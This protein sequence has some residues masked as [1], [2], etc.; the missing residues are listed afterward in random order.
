M[1]T[2]LVFFICCLVATAVGTFYFD[3]SLDFQHGDVNV[4]LSAETSQSTVFGDAQN[5]S[6]LAVDGDA[7]HQDSCIRTEEESGAWWE[8]DLG[9]DVQ[10]KYLKIYNFV[11][12]DRWWR[13]NL[14]SGSGGFTILSATSSAPE[15]F[16]PTEGYNHKGEISQVRE[17]YGA[18][19]L[20]RVDV[21]AR[22]IRIQRNSWGSL[23]LCEV[24]VYT[25]EPTLSYIVPDHVSATAPGEPS[26]PPAGHPLHA[27]CLQYLNAEDGTLF[28]PAMALVKA[29]M[30]G[31]LDCGGKGFFCRMKTDSYFSGTPRDALHNNYNYGYCKDAKEENPDNN[32]P[33]NYQRPERD[34]GHCHGSHL[35]TVYEELLEDHYYRRYRGN[36]VCC[37]G[38]FATPTK[39]SGEPENNDAWVPAT[40]LM[41][42][43]DFRGVDGNNNQY[44]FDGGC[45]GDVNR[46]E[47]VDPSNFHTPEQYKA[48]HTCWELKHF[49][50][51]PEF[52]YGENPLRVTTSNPDITPAY[53]VPTL[54]IIHC[55][56]NAGDWNG[57]LLYIEGRHDSNVVVLVS[58]S[59]TVQPRTL[60]H[61][62]FMDDKPWSCSHVE[63]VQ[64]GSASLRYFHFNELDAEG[65]QA[66]YVRIAPDFELGSPVHIQIVDTETCMMSPLKSS[67]LGSSDNG[68]RKLLL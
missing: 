7:H 62:D 50:V 42:R 16:S 59:Y 20:F 51:Q 54:D 19:T 49:G 26:C 22:Y 40:N 13:H 60:E 52:F 24:Q 10:V 55:A 64:V 53:P 46:D 15:S 37:C 34:D 57:C 23:R 11:D 48:A 39:T 68:N 65:Q 44:N 28:T 29:Y 27:A 1:R 58:A 25:T 33:G 61:L 8:L 36:L 2:S 67:V 14:G 43:C 9:D 66:G 35:D 41:E 5:Q 63:G 47:Y 17:M 31:P 56:G 38:E 45:G 3:T 4:A 32:F 18:V 30:A 6:Q 12:I 21:L